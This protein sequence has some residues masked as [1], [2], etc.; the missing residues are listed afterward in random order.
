MSANFIASNT[1]LAEVCAEL[2]A[3]AWIALDTEF[4]RERT[5]YAQLC[6]VQIGTPDLIVCIDPLSLDDLTPLLEVAYDPRVLKVMHA[7]RQDM[8]VFCDLHRTNGKGGTNDNRAAPSVP[9]PVFDTQIAAAYLGY[10]D[11]IG[12]GA[13]VKEITGVVLDK[14]HTRTDWTARPLSAEQLRYAED[15]V[16]YLRDVYLH[17]ALKLDET[18]RREWPNRDFA[19]LGDPLLYENDPRQA[20]QRIKHGHR[21]DQHTQLVLRELA[22]WRER[23][24]QLSNLPRSWVLRDT[25][26]TELAQKKP[27]DATGLASV[28]GMNEGALR[29]WGNQILAAI[30]QG[31]TVN[32]DT[33]WQ[34]PAVLTTE[35]MQ[36]YRRMTAQVDKIAHEQRISPAMLGTRREIQRLV[37]GDLSVDLLSGWRR[38]M[39]GKDLLAMLSQPSVSAGT[40]AEN[41]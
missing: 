11:Q 41:R 30:A 4:M 2:R 1:E 29:K 21:L 26:L 28:S 32:N 3:Q 22:A 33:L 23:A 39:I 20:W 15:D 34:T 19:H 18:G 27:R 12:Y 8:E 10:D 9:R 38:E 35:Q 6:L 40:P 25:M 5:Y 7:A 36:I 14:S 24:A 37:L 13:L 17:L 16:R 31:D